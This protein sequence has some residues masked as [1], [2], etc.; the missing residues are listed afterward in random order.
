M[1]RFRDIYLLSESQLRPE[2]IAVAFAKT[3]RSPESFREIAA[4]LT[5]ESSAQFH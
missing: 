5:D 4:G 2:V 1:A 3:S